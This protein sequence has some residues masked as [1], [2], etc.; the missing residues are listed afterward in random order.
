[1]YDA[2]THLVIKQAA[3]LDSSYAELYTEFFYPTL[4][5]SHVWSET[6]YRTRQAIRNWK[7][8][9]TARGVSVRT[10]DSF[11]WMSVWFC[12]ACNNQARMQDELGSDVMQSPFARVIAACSQIAIIA[13]LHALS[14]KWCNFEFC[15]ANAGCKGVLMVTDQ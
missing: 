5:L 7:L 11:R 6:A 10:E 8:E 13:P 1:M 4:F 9:R 3:T 14:R 12:T 2:C 15:L